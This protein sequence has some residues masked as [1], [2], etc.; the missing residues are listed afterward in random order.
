[1]IDLN[2][3]P[4]R[5]ELKWFAALQV[6]F[7][8]IV[9]FIVVRKTGSTGAATVIVSVSVVVGVIGWFVLGFMRAIYVVWMIAVYPIGW[10]LSHVLMGAI[11]YL[12][13]TPT[14]IMMK[15]CGKDPMQR[16]LDRAAQSYWQ[17]RPRQEGTRRYFRQF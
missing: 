3:N 1:M 2:L 16:T 14:A 7:F 6:I 13:V 17:P 10:T 9:A 4:T 8:G 11:F 5:K 15:L 12:V